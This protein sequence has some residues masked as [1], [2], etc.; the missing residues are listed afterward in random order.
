[1]RR[2]VGDDRSAQFDHAI[3]PAEPASRRMRGV[4]VPVAGQCGHVDAADEGDLVVDHDDLLVVAV[5]GPLPGVEH[6]REPAVSTELVSRRLRHLPRRLEDGDRRS[7]PHQQPDGHPLGE[8]GQEVPEGWAVRV[9]GEP[10]VRAGVPAGDVDVGSGRIKGCGHCGQSC[11][12]VDMNDRR[13]AAPGGKVI[14]RPGRRI[15]R[16]QRR[17]AETAEP[18]PVVSAGRCLQPV[19]KDSV[20]PVQAGHGVHDQEHDTR[21]GTLQ[22][23]VGLPPRCTSVPHWLNT[24]L[25]SDFAGAAAY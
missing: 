2:D 21:D 4:V 25:T 24:A 14:A 20:E 18:P 13:I 11:R 22:Q 17:G 23:R 15:R 7:G 19:P 12:A 9:A 3:V 5:Q 1:M 6:T 16:C 8:P 10:E